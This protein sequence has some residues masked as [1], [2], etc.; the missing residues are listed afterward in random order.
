[1][2]SLLCLDFKG[3][4]HHHALALPLGGAIWAMLHVRLF[5]RKKRVY[6]GVFFILGLNLIYYFWRFSALKDM[7]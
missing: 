3:Y 2:L 4:L 1:M 5:Q 7:V 6:I